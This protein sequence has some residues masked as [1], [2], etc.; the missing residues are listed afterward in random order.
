MTS[1]DP[2]DVTDREDRAP[3]QQRS[4]AD[5][6]C[7][8]QFCPARATI[9]D[10]VSGP[11]RNG[12]CRYH[13]GASVKLWPA[14]SALL[15][16]TQSIDETNAGLAHLGLFVRVPQPIPDTDS[17]E[18]QRIVTNL[19]EHLP[20]GETPNEI[21]ARLNAMVTT[22]RN[23]PDDW[24]Q[25]ICFRSRSG[26]Q[27]LRAA[28]VEAATSAWVKAGR[29]PEHSPIDEERAAIRAEGA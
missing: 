29:P 14:I 7:Q 19:D 9:F 26:D 12:R 18:G 4:E 8:A 16:R 28:Q 15:N 17:P 23:G 11:P 1:Y 5:Y 22:A 2:R 10:T 6:T 25:R 27:T 21:L 20:S 13:D 24:W 3:R